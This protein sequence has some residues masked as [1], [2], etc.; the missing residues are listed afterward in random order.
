MAGAHARSP[1][2]EHLQ[3]LAEM[4]ER[5]ARNSWGLT[6]ASKA[7]D[8]C[9]ESGILRIALDCLDETVRPDRSSVLLYDLDGELR[10][11]AWRNLSEEFRRKMEGHSPWSRSEKRPAPLVLPDIAV[12]PGV[13]L[14]RATILEE[15]I[16]SAAL[17]PADELDLALAG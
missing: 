11:K 14:F 3:A 8:P 6:A 1:S 9:A 2:L 10:F 17:L 13:D 15:G 4:A 5:I 16:R 7:P 12:A